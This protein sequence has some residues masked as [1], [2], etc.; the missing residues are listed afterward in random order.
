M[1]RTLELLVAKAAI[2]THDAMP[3]DRAELE[4]ALNDAL[5]ELERSRP[6]I[7]EFAPKVALRRVMVFPSV[8]VQVMR[9]GKQAT[10]IS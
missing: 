2:G 9:P 5:G 6:R 8:A 4:R 7:V 3:A 1:S 10:A